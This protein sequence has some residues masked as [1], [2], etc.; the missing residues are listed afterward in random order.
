MFYCIFFNFFVS[1]ASCWSCS[2]CRPIF[3][4]MTQQKRKLRIYISNTYTPSKPEGED[5]EKVASWELRVEG[6]LLEEVSEWHLHFKNKFHLHNSTVSLKNLCCSAL[7]P[8]AWLKPRNQMCSWLPSL[9]PTSSA[10]SRTNSYTHA[11]TLF[12]FWNR[13]ETMSWN[14]SPL[15]SSAYCVIWGITKDLFFP[16]SALCV[17]PR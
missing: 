17:L 2:C 4:S 3:F 11:H 1:A 8:S 15:P 13:I 5:S 9:H 12:L 10:H 14:M 7:G 6:K 16:P